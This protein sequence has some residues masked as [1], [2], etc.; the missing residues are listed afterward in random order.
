MNDKNATIK[1]KKVGKISHHFGNIGV[2]VIDLEKG[3]KVGDRIRVKG[4]TTDFEQTVDSMQ[5]DKEQVA[6]AGKGKSI[7]LK[8]EEK[9]RVGDEVYKL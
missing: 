4:A 3:L 9:I 1:G 6:K 8:V 2:A 7:G 5:I